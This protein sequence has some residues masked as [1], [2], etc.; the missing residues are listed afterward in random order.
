M[1]GQGSPKY[2]RPFQRARSP[3]APLPQPPDFYLL[4]SNFW[5][6]IPVFCILISIPVRHE[7]HPRQTIPHAQ[8][9]S[10][11]PRN[12]LLAPLLPEEGWQGFPDGVVG[13]DWVLPPAAGE[14]ELPRV[15]TRG[16]KYPK[17]AEARFQRATDAAT[18]CLVR[19]VI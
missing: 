10:R 1:R 16:P 9:R 4:I 8:E 11:L 2:T 7:L 17:N 6:L 19:L 15:S 13:G 18:R 5:F 12:E 3:K 14:S